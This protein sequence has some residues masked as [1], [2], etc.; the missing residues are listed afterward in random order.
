MNIFV[1]DD[2]RENMVAVAPNRRARGAAHE[3]T[4]AETGVSSRRRRRRL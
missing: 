3:E 2:H 4:S 1:D